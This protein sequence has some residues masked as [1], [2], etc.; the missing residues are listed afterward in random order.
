VL[1]LL[2]PTAL[3][4]V[5]ATAT[6][7][8]PR[9]LFRTGVRAWPAIFLAFGIELVLYNPPLDQQPWVMAVG[10]WMWLAAQTI[11]LTVLVVNGWAARSAVLWPWRVAALGVGLNCLVIALNGGHMPQS[12]EA[13]VAVFGAS[14]IDPSRLQNVAAVSV[15]T[16]LAW[17]GD[18]IAE[19]AWLPR[20]NVVSIGDLLLSLGIASWV[21][22]GS[23]NGTRIDGAAPPHQ[24]PPR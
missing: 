16:R 7:G 2:A 10:P 19:P 8:S 15:D 20:P 12:T 21:T 14:R 22:M 6:G 13:A 9:A 5:L 1:W 18:V 23:R 17:L 4:L 3:G 24:A 11:F